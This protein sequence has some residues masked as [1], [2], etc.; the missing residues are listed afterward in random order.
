M[1]QDCGLKLFL[2]TELARIIE[3]ARLEIHGGSAKVGDIDSSLIFKVMGA[4]VSF[5][6]SMIIITGVVSRS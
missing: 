6:K 2:V 5:H 4:F 1:V 3:N